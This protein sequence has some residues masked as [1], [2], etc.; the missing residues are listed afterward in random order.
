MLD[1]IGSGARVAFEV[2]GFNSSSHAGWSVV[3]HGKAEEIWLPDELED[4]RHLPINPWAPGDRNHYVRIFPS[5]I[6]GRRIV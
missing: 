5:A 1:A 4:A 3:L 2:D 6:T